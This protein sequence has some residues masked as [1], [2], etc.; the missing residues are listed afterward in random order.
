MPTSID[1]CSVAGSPPA[2]PG[3]PYPQD[4]RGWAGP[5]AQPA[6]WWRFL[7]QVSSLCSSSSHILA[8]RC[9]VSHFTT[10]SLR[11]DFRKPVEVITW[12]SLHHSTVLSFTSPVQFCPSL[13]Q[14]SIV[15]HF[16]S[17]VLSFTSPAQTVSLPGDSG[18]RL[19]QPLFLL[20]PTCN[21][22]HGG[23]LL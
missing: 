23:V 1:T 22:W 5:E 16:T 21:Q 20:S 9:L 10:Q 3:P 11:N 8:N 6:P 4:Q 12:C 15:L 2:P 13:H 7:G 18:D 17:P 14:S 19:W